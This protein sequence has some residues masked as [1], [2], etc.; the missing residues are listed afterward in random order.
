[1][2]AVALDSSRGILA[3]GPSVAR[4]AA[5]EHA[6]EPV[7]SAPPGRGKPLA[8]FRRVL[9]EVAPH[10]NRRIAGAQ[11][12]G[13]FLDELGA[14]LE[15]A[16]MAADDVVAGRRTHADGA[17]PRTA[18]ERELTKLGALW[19]ERAAA[20][21]G[22]LDARLEYHPEGESRQRFAIRGLQLASLRDGHPETLTFAIGL[23]GQRLIASVGIEPGLTD[24]DIVQRF[25]RALAPA[26]VRAGLDARGELA[27]SVPEAQWPQVREAVALMGDGRRFPTGQFSQVRT[28][29]EPPVIAIDRWRL[30][31]LGA[32]QRVVREMQQAGQAVQRARAHVADAMTA[33]ERSLERPAKPDT[34]PDHARFADTFAALARRNDY[35]ALAAVAPALTGLDRHRVAVLL[36]SY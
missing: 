24:A 36:H 1:M 28:L 8:T 7:R 15:R 16:R 26:G 33:M 9:G 3:A 18:Y 19:S 12:A 31:E 14:Q 23:R 25:D 22:T 29:A 27:F 4:T 13:A 35:G 5:P 2:Q 32:A 20:S 30:D 21:G 11:Q 34:P 17:G 10:I 6:T